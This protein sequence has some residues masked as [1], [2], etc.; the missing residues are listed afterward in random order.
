[1]LDRRSALVGMTQA[2]GRLA[3]RVTERPLD[4]IRWTPPQL[5]W[6]QNPRKRKLFRAGNQVGKTWAGLA[7]VIWRATGLHP[8]LPCKKP[9]VEIWIVCTTWP[10]SVGIMKKFWE[11]VPKHLIRPTSFDPKWGF[12]KEN[13]AV[14]FRNGS[15]VRFRT[16][17]QGADALA[18]WTV[19]YVLV[20]EPTDP[21]VYQELDRR[22]M[23][24]GGEMGLTLTPLHRP[25]D[26]LRELCRDGVVHDEHARLTV[27]NLTP[28]GAREPLRLLDG[29][30]MDQAWIELQWKMVLK[31]FAP[32]VLDG[33]WEQRVEGAVFSAYDPDQ[34]V[35]EEVPDVD[36]FAVAGFDW[37]EGHFRNIGILGGVDRTGEYPRVHFLA[38]VAND[39]SGLP[40][41]DARGTLEALDEIGWTWRE[42]N[43]ATGDKP[44]VGQAGRKSNKDMMAALER[45]LRRRGELEGRQQLYP[46]IKTAKTGKGGNTNTLWRGVTWLHH[47][48]LRPG[49][50]TVHPR[51]ERL[52]ESLQ[53]WDG[54]SDSEFKDPCDG[55]RYA[56][57]PLY[58]RGWVGN[59]AGAYIAS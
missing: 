6:L 16:T 7:E 14:V 53:K 30:L 33:E 8:Y 49:H 2:T 10:Q 51:C 36:L 44:T 58:M 19:D 45:E 17:K 57:W 59:D 26:Y 37:G 43:A 9:P 4:Y 52:N 1:M 29:T 48:M 40:E 20:D 3:T 38:E 34:H 28:I 56:T 54:S 5:R 32:V 18:G 41:D 50:F 42:L 23:R 47:A 55:A 31:R 25:C 12:G 22:L 11:L 27:A 24:T 13:P 39:G 46:R 15:L 21:D 35:T